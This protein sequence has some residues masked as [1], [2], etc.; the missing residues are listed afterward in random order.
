MVV[1][2]LLLR[3][4]SL[5]LSFP[6]SLPPSLLRSFSGHDEDANVRSAVLRKGCASMVKYGLSN[7]ADFR[8]HQEHILRTYSFQLHHLKLARKRRCS[9]SHSQRKCT[10]STQGDALRALAACE[11]SLWVLAKSKQWQFAS[12][13]NG[14]G[15]RHPSVKISRPVEKPRLFKAAIVEWSFGPPMNFPWC[16]W[17]KKHRSS[18]LRLLRLLRRT[19]QIA[20]GTMQCHSFGKSP[21]PSPFSMQSLT[22]TRWPQFS[23]WQLA[24]AHSWKPASPEALSTTACAWTRNTST[25]SRPLR[26][27][28]PAG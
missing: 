13:H 11:G 21:S 14:C 18:A 3:S 1:W 9:L 20:L 19:G 8:S 16:H 22:S 27:E 7:V 24:P 17:L 25:G 12:Q 2:L 23:M 28:P 10:W 6:P 15:W 4:L 26:T 5:S